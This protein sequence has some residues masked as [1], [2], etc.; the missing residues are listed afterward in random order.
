MTTLIKK[1]YQNQIK[2]ND[3]I[4]IKGWIRTRRSSKIGISF[5]NVYDGSYISPIQVVV[6]KTI[7]NYYDDILNLTTGCSVSI[8]GVL[9]LSNGR[10]QKYEI[11]ANHIKVIGWVTNPETYPISS[12][13]H[14]LEYLRE[15][16]HLRP[17]TNF[18]GAISRIR[19]VMAYSLHKFLSKNG[20]YWVPTPIITSID[21]E[22][23][24]AMFNVS[25]FDLN[26]IPKTN[27]KFVNFKKDFFGKKS[28]LTVSGQL[29]LETY[30]CSLSKVYTFGP[31][32][33]A[34]NSNTSRHLSEFWMLEVEESFS[35]LKKIINFSE[36]M[37]KYVIRNVIHSSL[38]ELLFLEKFLNK[39]L[40]SKLNKCLETNFIQINYK[41]A[42]KILKKSSTFKNQPIF[43]GMDLS[44][45]HEKYLVQN[46]FKNPIIILNYPKKLKPFYMRVNNDGKTVSAMDI[47]MPEVGE[48]LGGSQREE[49]L[50]IL[51]SRIHEL[52]LKKKDY[53]WYRDIRKY[54]TV[55]HSGFGLG[56]ERF[57]SYITSVP[58]VRDLI[59]FPRTV[60][61]S[62]F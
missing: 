35:T 18:I 30:A 37:I 1:I 9:L 29:T 4:K 36:I 21:T 5:L 17:R 49:R 22:G 10:K 8:I 23:N 41:D 27:N 28:F 60:K 59:P 6:K 34:E 16:P 53:S 26:N 45:F 54:G 31:T 40:L 25:T 2:V 51:D 57:M 48:I 20:Y 50:S 32:F 46:Y 13:K 56:F 7:D 38:E 33:R 58:N 52:K 12:K 19:S 44:S 55:P 11:Q 61:N 42:I 47:L 39:D 3:I 15:V 24:G 14:S 62:K 43:F